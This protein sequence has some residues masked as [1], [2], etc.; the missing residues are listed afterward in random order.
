[1]GGRRSGGIGRRAGLKIRFPP[2]SVGSIPT[3]G[4][5]NHAGSAFANALNREAA[6]RWPPP[7][8][9]CARRD[10]TPLGIPGVLAWYRRKGG[11]TASGLLG[12]EVRAGKC[13][14]RERRRRDSGDH[15]LPNLRAFDRGRAGAL[16]QLVAVLA[17]EEDEM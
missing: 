5:R 16:V 12:D 14:T 9:R 10:S 15:L 6:A 7:P 17:L 8:R 1:M 13:A 2:G 11:Q 3:F 4:T